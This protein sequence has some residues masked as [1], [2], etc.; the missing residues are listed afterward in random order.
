MVLG[1]L[2]VDKSFQG[3]GFG[4]DLMCDAVLRT[5]QAG[6]YAGIR[7][8]LVHAILEGA[9]RFYEGFGVV[10]S[11]IEPM[12]VMITLAEALKILGGRI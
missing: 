5:A 1:R 8:I 4:A 12:T 2:A 11:P 3:K 10:P 9:K 7:G 6:E